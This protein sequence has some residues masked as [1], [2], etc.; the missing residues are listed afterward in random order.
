[1]EAGKSTIKKLLN[2]QIQLKLIHSLRID[3]NLGSLT[4]VSQNNSN[5]ATFPS[6]LNTSKLINQ[7]DGN[8]YWYKVGCIQHI[9]SHKIP[10]SYANTVHAFFFSE[11]LAPKFEIFPACKFD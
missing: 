6:L 10:A 1:M 11:I 9:E 3:S 2:I 4:Q 7:Y 5:F 8:L